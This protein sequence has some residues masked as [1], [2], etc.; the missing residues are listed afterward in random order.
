MDSYNDATRNPNS[1]FKYV[2]S[3]F[4]TK[5]IHFEIVQILHGSNLRLN[6]EIIDDS[7]GEVFII[8]P[9]FHLITTKDALNIYWRNLNFD[10]IKEYNDK[11]VN[12][13]GVSKYYWDIHDSYSGNLIAE[14]RSGIFELDGE[15]SVSDR[16]LRKFNHIIDSLDKEEEAESCEE[17]DKED[18]IHIHIETNLPSRDFF[19]YWFNNDIPVK[20][21]FRIIILDN[22]TNYV[23]NVKLDI[24]GTY[25]FS[26]GFRP[27]LVY[28]KDTNPVEVNIYSDELTM[29]K[30]IAKKV[31][32]YI[33]NYDDCSLFQKF[34]QPVIEYFNKFL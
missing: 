10:I 11:I 25:S 9:D 18:N 27:G 23:Y 16:T 7:Y 17:S 20:A 22:N 12:I 13:L 4:Y 26:N 34:H 1:D 31:I 8:E 29:T 21:K 28:M 30:E 24:S 15:I 5:D 2:S 32:N 19:S 6:T 3:L 14:C 33:K